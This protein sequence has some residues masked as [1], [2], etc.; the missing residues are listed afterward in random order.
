MR[1]DPW[2]V[3]AVVL[4]GCATAAALLALRARAR[5]AALSVLAILGVAGWR[6]AEG[7]R[8]TQTRDARRWRS[9][10]TGLSVEDLAPEG[11]L[12]PQ[13]HAAQ[14]RV[15]RTFDHVLFYCLSGRDNVIDEC[16]H[17]T[18]EAALAAT[19][20]DAKPAVTAIEN[21]VAGRG[22]CKLPAATPAAPRTP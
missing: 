10:C 5:L 4:L 3:V 19:P 22:D 14:F 6:F 18:H 12:Q 21:A 13:D 7:Q 8:A 15:E 17:R 20:E 9:L 1:T 2:L 11:P 16:Q